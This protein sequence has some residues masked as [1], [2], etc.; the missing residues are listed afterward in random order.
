MKTN[1]LY[2]QRYLL[3]L[4]AISVSD[5]LIQRL[6]QDCCSCCSYS[7]ISFSGTVHRKKTCQRTS[8]VKVC[9]GHFSDYSQAEESAAFAMS[10][11]LGK[12]SAIFSNLL[13]YHSSFM[14]MN[15]SVL[16]LWSLM[17]QITFFNRMY[18]FLKDKGL[19]CALCVP[20]TSFPTLSM[21][22]FDFGQDYLSTCGSRGNIFLWRW[23]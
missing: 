8:I 23:F 14:H 20:V 17:F 15:F 19:A 5:L 11:S 12:L 2:I 4:P 7:W 13:C 10:T 1:R 16:P 22:S 21:I 3:P 18:L 9:P 6:H